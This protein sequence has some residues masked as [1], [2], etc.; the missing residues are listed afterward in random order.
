MAPDACSVRKRRRKRTEKISVINSLKKGLIEKK[1]Q[2]R[3]ETGHGKPYGM[4][5]EKKD[6]HGKG[7]AVHNEEG[8]E[9]GTKRQLRICG[10]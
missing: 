1:K 4:F 9:K 7:K 2:D 10:L 8:K 6:E 3:K 5:T